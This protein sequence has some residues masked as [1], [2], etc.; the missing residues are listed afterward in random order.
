MDDAPSTTDN[1]VAMTSNTTVNGAIAT[2]SISIKIPPFWPSDPE[3][4]FAQVEAQFAVK[5][6]TVQH[7]K[8]SH[9]I[10]ALSPEAATEVRDLILTPPDANP[11][12][13]LKAALTERVSLSKRRKLH[14]VLHAE[15]LGDRKPSQ[16]LCQL[17][18]LS[19]ITDSDLLRELFLQRLPSNVQ[20]GL[21]SHPGKPLAELA[22][23][24][25]GMIQ[26]VESH[27]SIAQVETPPTAEISSIRSE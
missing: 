23:I 4:L 5:Q 21:L 15:E 8:Y 19:G 7:T 24:A 2:Y 18:Q 27:Q 22:V 3:L 20:V 13:V 9:V 12:D 26:L 11:Y 10:A 17:Q 1:S 16:L 14:Q 25:D 6:I